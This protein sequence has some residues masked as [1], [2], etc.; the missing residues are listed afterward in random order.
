MNITMISNNDEHY[1][2][3][4]QWWTLQW[5]FANRETNYD[6]LDKNNLQIEQYEP[7]KKQGELMFFGREVVPALVVALAVLL[8]LNSMR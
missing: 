7:H 2:D 1:K 4:K 8:V 5:P 6:Q 3:I